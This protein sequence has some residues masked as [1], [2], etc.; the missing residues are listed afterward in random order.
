MKNLSD[1]MF[2]WPFF[3]LRA[4]GTSI[5]AT[6]PRLAQIS[7]DR[8][9]PS[10]YG[11]STEDFRASRYKEVFGAD[12]CSGGLSKKTM[13]LDIMYD[14]L[15]LKRI[16]QRGTWLFAFTLRS[17]KSIF[18]GIQ[19]CPP[20]WNFLSFTFQTNLCCNMWTWQPVRSQNVY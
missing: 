17:S 11:S 18:I 8:P 14:R 2:W 5:F 3:D 10:R 19:I 4:C 20:G 13:F 6:F 16:Y 15:L 9:W 1:R 7:V 12:L